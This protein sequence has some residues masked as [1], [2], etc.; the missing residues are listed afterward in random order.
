MSPGRV[1]TLAVCMIFAG[2][3]SCA[4]ARAETVDRIVANVNGEIILYSELRQQIKILEKNMPTL[5]VADPTKKA[6]IEREILTQMIRQKLADMEAERLKVTVATSEVDLRVQQILE[7]N[8]STMA[9][10]EVSLKATGQTLDKFRAQIKKDMERERLVE[11]V[12]NSKVLIG[13]KQIEAF[14][15]GEKGES[16]STSQK[17]HLG[18]IVL[19]VGDKYAKPE[20]AEKTG[21]EILDKLQ[22]GADFRSLAKQYSKGP[23][24]QDG[25]DVGYLAGDELAPFIAQGIHNLRKDQ[26]SGLVQ[27]PGGYYIIKIFDI[28]SKKVSKSD[29]ALREKVRR[30]LYEQEVNRKFEEWVHDLESKAFIQISL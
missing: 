20:D 17:V 12:C 27:G 28:D 23:A 4:N 14:L 22:G 30:N 9:Q 2:V 7:Q 11:R 5:N 8:H 18:L 13:D 21:R 24:A 25:G 1:S 10:L 19:P 3:L 29:A 26:V 15:S 6:Q 16:A